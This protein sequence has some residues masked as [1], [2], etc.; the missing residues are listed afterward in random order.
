MV[1]RW[2]TP[3]CADANGARPLGNRRGPSPGLNRTATKWPTPL[4]GTKGQGGEGK[5]EGG[6]TLQT[7]AS[8]WMTPTTA[9]EADNRGSNKTS[10]PASL[11]QQARLY[12]TPKAEPY[13]SSQNGI[14]R[15]GPSARPSAGTPSP[16]T[17]ASRGDLPFLPDPQTPTDGDDA[18]LRSPGS[19]PPSRERNSRL[20]SLVL[21]P[22][23][24][25]ALMGLPL[26]WTR[27]DPIDSTDYATWET[28]FCRHKPPTRFA[29]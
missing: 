26:G 19:S 5:R 28:R 7:S 4:A 11:G 2:P 23:F 27:T 3:V 17:M 15:H 29:R 16:E 21:N 20:L 6:P 9:P 13:G 18:S 10:G 22:M 8:R 12:P 1:Q 24:V 14:N 25:E